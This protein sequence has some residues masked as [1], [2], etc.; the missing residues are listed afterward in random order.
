MKSDIKS[1]LAIIKRTPFQNE[2]SPS[3]TSF[4]D[5]ARN[6]HTDALIIRF[7]TNLFV[8]KQFFDSTKTILDVY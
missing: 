5:F 7:L 8:E 3:L 6:S 4:R 1:D 2:F